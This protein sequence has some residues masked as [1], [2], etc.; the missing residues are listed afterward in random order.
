VESGQPSP[1]KVVGQRVGAFLIDSL[2]FIALGAIAWFALTDRLDADTSS[3][4]GFVIGHTR[5]AFTSSTNRGIWIAIVI[6]LLL[7][8]FVVMTGL[9]GTSPGKLAT[10]IRTVRADGAPPGLGRAALRS[11]VGLAADGF[12]YFLPGLTGLILTLATKDNQRVGDIA[13]ST[14]VVRTEAAGRPIAEVVPK[15][16]AATAPAAA[17][18]QHPAGWYADPR[19]EARLRWWDGS[20]WTEHVAQ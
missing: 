17:P 9:R 2:V 7:A 20:A 12:P 19:G 3:G 1:T 5:Y 16:P 8:I 10:G 11:A 13:A 15:T 6:L 18:A 14:W 4:G